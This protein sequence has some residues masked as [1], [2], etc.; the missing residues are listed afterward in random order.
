[1]TLLPHIA[2]RLR[3][4][5][6]QADTAMSSATEAF[7]PGHREL[8]VRLQKECERAADDIDQYVETMHRA[9]AQASGKPG[10]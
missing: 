1:M 8:V 2:R 10:L 7:F 3:Q 4:Q 5:A 6:A 9:A